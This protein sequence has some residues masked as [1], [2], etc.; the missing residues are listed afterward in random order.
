MAASFTEAMQGGA[1]AP[2]PAPSEAPAPPAPAATPTSIGTDPPLVDPRNGELIDLGAAESEQLLDVVLYCRHHEGLMQTWRKACED[3]MRRRMG[4]RKVAVFGDKEV[5]VDSGRGK[6]WDGQMLR[7]VL[8]DLVEQHVIAAGAIPDGLIK[9][10]AVN[11]T[12]AN[13]LLDRLSGEHRE[14]VEE[15]FRWVQKS[16][17]RLTVSPVPDLADALPKGDE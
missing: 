6:E 9:P 4:D 11:G 14:V 1:P 2:T 5:K 17:P 7:S 15:C 8:V 3:E 12:L 10:P 16:R 13:Q